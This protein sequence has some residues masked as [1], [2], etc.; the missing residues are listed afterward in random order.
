M[1][2][3][4]GG[5]RRAT[6][7]ELRVGLVVSG[8]SDDTTQS[9]A[10]DAAGTCP[11]TFDGAN[12]KACGPSGFR[13]SF[14]Y[15]CVGNLYQVANCDCTNGTFQCFDQTASTTPI[16]VGS[17]PACTAQPSTMATCPATYAATDGVACSVAGALCA[18]KGQVC[19]G[20]QLN[21]ECQCVAGGN[22]SSADGGGLAYKCQRT[23]CNDE[24]GAGEA[25]S[26]A[27]ITDAATD[28]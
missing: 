24:A 14:E 19:D 10:P 15:Y 6:A 22:G 17:E 27:G 4:G 16:A 5:V 9:E 2:R 11:A 12:G 20:L 3:D 23:V 13:C 26:E 18:Y 21:D 25:G 1:R 7:G 8:C 28:G